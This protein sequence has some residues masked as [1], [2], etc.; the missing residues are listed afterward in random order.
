MNTFRHYKKLKTESIDCESKSACVCAHLCPTLWDPVDCNLPGYSVHGIIPARILEWVA[1]YSSRRSS[2][3]GRWILFSE[4]PGKPESKDSLNI[5][6]WFQGKNIL[7]SADTS[8][9]KS[10]F[11]PLLAA[12]PQINPLFRM[13]WLSQRKIEMFIFNCLEFPGDLTGAWHIVG[14]L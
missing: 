5:I 8:G 14:V 10:L 9:K 2:C 12:R 3:P 7:E 13:P 6:L 1:I 11:T 4:P